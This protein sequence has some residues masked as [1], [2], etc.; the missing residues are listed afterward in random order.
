MSGNMHKTFK[1]LEA[2]RNLAE[3][4]YH[5]ITNAT[6]DAIIM[7]TPEGKISFWNPAAEKIF[8]YKKKEILG[9]NLHLIVAPGKYYEQYKKGFKKFK[10]T[11]KGPLIGK[12]LELTAIKKNRSEFPI[13]LSLSATKVDGAWVSIGIVRDITQRKIDEKALLN[14]QTILEKT[15]DQRTAE[16]KKANTELSEANVA[17][18]ILLTK[19]GEQSAEI[20]KKVLNNIDTYVLPYLEDLL[21][22]LKNKNNN[23][24]CLTIKKNLEQVTSSFNQALS[25]KYRNLTSREIQVVDLIR[26]GKSTKEMAEFL[27]LSIFT[28]ETYRSNLRKK[29]D[30]KNKKINLRSFLN[31]IKND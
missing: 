25:L 3:Q 19:C 7:I 22:R 29:F 24:L 15:V 12:M 6:I 4:K 8:G 9:K 21:S 10:Q 20:E 30:L 16:L 18:K 1:K 11:G 14:A 5:L 31:S 2:E 13:G 26:H 27:N 23:S 17:L 28:I